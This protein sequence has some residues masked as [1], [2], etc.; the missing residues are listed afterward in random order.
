M[1]FEIEKDLELVLAGARAAGDAALA[2]SCELTATPDSPGGWKVEIAVETEAEAFAKI[3][4]MVNDSDVPLARAR[5][6]RLYLAWKGHVESQFQ[7]GYNFHFGRNIQQDYV[8]A[9]YW[10]EKAAVSGHA[11]AQNNLGVLLSDGLGGKVDNAKAVYWYMK[12]AEGGDRVA[13][14]NLGEHFF[15]GAGV[16]KSYLKAAQ[17]LKEY[18]KTSP[19]NAKT[20]R[21]LAE[22]YEHGVGGR[23]GLRLAMHHYQEASDFGSHKARAALR[24]LGARAY[25][26]D[27]RCQKPQ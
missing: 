4:R 9:R 6:L 11:A 12:S 20:H 2:K 3:D 1:V 21:L 16:R 8:I 10:Y 15:D 26:R 13:K 7:E 27:V 18:L 24:R 14:G 25:R 22:C 17:L 5:Q 23:H 19:Y